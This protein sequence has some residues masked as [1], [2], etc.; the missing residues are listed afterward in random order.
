MQVIK[1][2]RDFGF[3]CASGED[4]SLECTPALNAVV[5]IFDSMHA[6]APTGIAAIASGRNLVTVVDEAHQI[7]QDRG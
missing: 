5:C 7:V 6:M 3:L 4:T 1:D 2:I